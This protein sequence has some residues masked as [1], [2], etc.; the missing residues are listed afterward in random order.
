MSFERDNE[1]SRALI[2][3]GVDFYMVWTKTGRVPRYAHS[4]RES[5]VHEAERLAEIHP[6]KKFIVLKAESKH[7]VPAETQAA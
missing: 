5:A 2:A 3:E 1:T 4:T 7:S 6:G